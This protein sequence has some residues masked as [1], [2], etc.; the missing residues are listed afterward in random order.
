MVKWKYQLKL[1]IK[2]REKSIGTNGNCILRKM[3]LKF[4]NPRPNNLCKITFWNKHKRLNNELAIWSGLTRAAGCLFDE[5]AL[6]KDKF[7]LQENFW[8][9]GTKSDCIHHPKP[10]W[11]SCIKPE[12]KWV[13]LF[14]V[15]TYLRISQKKKKH[16]TGKHVK[17]W[18]NLLCK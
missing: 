6:K 13:S 9:D 11:Q 18:T 7:H 1:I 4:Q 16:G 14:L 12:S 3:V 15:C 17:K 10:A 5:I 2:T 8:L